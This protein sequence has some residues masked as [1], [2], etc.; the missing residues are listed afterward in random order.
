MLQHQCIVKFFVA[1]ILCCKFDSIEC[2]MKNCIQFVF[3]IL[4][5][6]SWEYAEVIWQHGVC[7]CKWVFLI[8]T[9]KKKFNNRVLNI[10]I[11]YCEAHKHKPFENTQ[12]MNHQLKLIRLEVF[13]VAVVV[14]SNK[15]HLQYR[16]NKKSE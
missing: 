7:V 12:Q 6:S 11:N 13:F 14:V 2:Q 15:T 16:R 3:L 10:T 8:C 5:F 1:S 9:W 4:L